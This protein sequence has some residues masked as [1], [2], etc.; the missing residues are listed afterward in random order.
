MRI[1]LDYLMAVALFVTGLRLSAFFSGSETGFYRLSHPRL[2]IDAG[3]GDRVAGRLLWFARHPAYFVAT[4]LVGNNIANYLITLAIGWGVALSL[5]SRAD[6]AEFGM[7]LALSPV[8]FLAGELLPK[9]VYYRA[10]LYFLRREARWFLMVFRLFFPITWPLVMLTRGVERATGQTQ[11]PAEVVLGRNRLAQLLQ[12]GHRE[13]VLTDLQSRLANGLLRIAP[14]PVT[15]SMIPRHRVLGVDDL[16]SRDTMLREAKAYGVSFLAVRRAGGAEDW[17]GYVRINE[18]IGSS[19]RPQTVH[20][21]P[22]VSDRLSKLE[23]LNVLQMTSAPYGAVERDGNVIGIVSR[24]G[25]IEQ[26]FRTP[27][28]AQ[29]R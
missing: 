18:L 17:Y 16:A 29:L 12:H 5:G 8:V 2:A 24:T 3:A 27:A 20:A 11:Q 26:L 25:L 23:A 14:Q 22:H 7:T 10:P 9:N 1:W 4:C 6:A 28:A 15:A 13:G 21:M 19:D